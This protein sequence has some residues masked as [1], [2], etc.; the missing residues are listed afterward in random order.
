MH[1]SWVTQRQLDDVAEDFK[2][3]LA[4]LLFLA[5]SQTQ[6]RYVRVYTEVLLAENL[7]NEASTLVFCNIVYVYLQ[8]VCESVSVEP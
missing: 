3:K 1:L 8:I 2:P 4:A 7:F 5:N 6:Q